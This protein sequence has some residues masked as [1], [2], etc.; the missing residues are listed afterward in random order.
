MLLD[1]QALYGSLITDLHGLGGI[2]EREYR[3][4]RL[5]YTVFLVG[6]VVSALLV[7]AIVFLF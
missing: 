4:L 6:L 7:V 1:P 2:I 5:A 3:L